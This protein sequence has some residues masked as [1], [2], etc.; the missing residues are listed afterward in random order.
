MDLIPASWN[1]DDPWPCV[2]VVSEKS[3][4][5]A[6]INVEYLNYF[7]ANF[8]SLSY[9]VGPKD[10]AVL[11]CSEGKLIGLIMPIYTKADYHEV[12]RE[13]LMIKGTE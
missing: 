7:R 13:F 11:V 12:R 3:K 9:R 2:W 1:Y 4:K 6:K 5:F 10:R 8:P